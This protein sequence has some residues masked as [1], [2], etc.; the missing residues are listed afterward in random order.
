MALAARSQDTLSVDDPDV[1]AY[2]R[3]E[4]DYFDADHVSPQAADRGTIFEEIKGRDSSSDLLQRT[5]EATTTGTTSGATHFPRTG[6]AASIESGFAGPQLTV[7]TR[8]NASTCRRAVPFWMSRS[9]LK[10]VEYFRLGS[11]CQ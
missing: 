9:S 11:A 4:N 1:L 5:L 6:R 7:P 8:G 2:L 3:A 10:T